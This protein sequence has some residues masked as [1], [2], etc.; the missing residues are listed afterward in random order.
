ML[1]EEAAAKVTRERNLI[2]SIHYLR[3][4]DQKKLPVANTP[5]GLIITD[6][7]RFTMTG[8]LFLFADT[9]PCDPNRILLFATLANIALMNEYHNWYGDG[10]FRIAPEIFYQVYTVHI[11][12]LGKSLPMVYGLLANKTAE[13]YTKMFGLIKEKIQNPPETFGVDFEQATIKAFQKNFKETKLDGCFFHFAQALFRNFKLKV[14]DWKD[15]WKEEGCRKTFRSL[16]SLAFLPPK[17]VI[18]AFKLIQTTAPVYMSNFITDYFENKYIGS[19]DQKSGKRKVPVFPIKLWS[20]NQRVLD[21]LPR[22]NNSIEAWHKAFSAAIKSHT[23]V[24]KLI[25]KFKKEQV[26][27]ENKSIQ[28][29]VDGPDDV[30]RSTK[31]KK[32]KRIHAIVSACTKTNIEKTIAD[33]VLVLSAVDED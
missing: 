25:E 2:Q 12:K 16:E 27:T 3:D 6:Y 24:S 8:I 13:T 31:I 4:K 28:L 23:L 9:G 5:K 29:T 26:K 21:G 1:S 15:H 22:T 7:F 32:D 18:N 17:E 19:I 20:V 10:T 11:L 30:R 33:L 14:I